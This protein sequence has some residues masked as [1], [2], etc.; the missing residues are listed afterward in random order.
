MPPSARGR[1]GLFAPQYRVLT[2]SIVLLIT[3]LAFDE[4]SITAIM[5]VIARDLHGM[6][7]YA[8]AFSLALVASLVGTVAGGGWADRSG[9]AAPLRAG[10]GAFVAGLL[11]A[12]LAPDMG[13][14]VAGRAIQ[15]L[16]AGNVITAIYVL[17]ARAYPERMRPRVFTVTSA[18][19]VVP[20][21]IGPTAAA[22]VA[23]DL[24]WRIVFLGL[25]ALVVPAAIMLRPALRSAGG[26]TPAAPRS[27]L[28]AAAVVAT[29]TAVLL[30]GIDRTL[31]P[32]AVVGAAG[33]CAGLPRLL[34][35]GAL[36]LRRG[37]PAAVVTRGL[38][39]AAF[40]GTEVLIPLS[41]IS[42]HAFTATESGTVLTVG[43]LGWSAGSWL[44][45]RSSRSR[46][47]FTVLGAACLAMGVGGVAAVTS[48]SSAGGWAW[49][50]APGW[51]FAGA[52]MGL[53]LP[54]LNVIVMDASA[55]DQQG[56]NSS[57]LQIADTLG[58]ALSAGLAG[59]IVVGAGSLRTG[60]DIA[61]ILTIGIA[62]AAI[63]VALRTR[64]R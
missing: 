34:P 51:V 26:G 24:S 29:G 64:S 55:D 8:W 45:G 21:L 22:V 49:L 1:E 42:L 17:V 36:S 12:G 33:I 14:F 61:E 46:P 50:T 11:V 63:L 48:M 47:F 15:G 25:I 20:S 16:G 53:C 7:L 5:P 27:R 19:W 60:A 31:I 37:L 41:L 23:E 59:A 39:S 2:S 10:V 44:Q 6:H 32:V 43:A 56:V 30:W 9:P 57:G 18:A 62:V 13:V 3:L 35:A 40:F 52:G 28:L 58:A 54:A 4:M 38:M